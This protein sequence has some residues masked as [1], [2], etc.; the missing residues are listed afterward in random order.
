MHGELQPSVH[1]TQKLEQCAR[2]WKHCRQCC[3]KGKV[4]QSILACF[5]LIEHSL[6]LPFLLHATG[7]CYCYQ[8]TYAAAVA[9]K[10]ATTHQD[11]LLLLPAATLLPP[12]S[13][14]LLLHTKLYC[15]FCQSSLNSLMAG[16]NRCPLHFCCSPRCTLLLHTD[17]HFCCCQSCVYS[18]TTAS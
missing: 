15:Y 5:Q 10:P 14:M 6:Q 18:P 3:S 13:H 11:G 17:H 9:A 1:V 8:P 4:L 2:L 16:Y 12:M 7:S